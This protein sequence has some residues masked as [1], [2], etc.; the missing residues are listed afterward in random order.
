MQAEVHAYNIKLTPAMVTWFPFILRHIISVISL[1][2]YTEN[3]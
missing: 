2:K 1:L 3:V